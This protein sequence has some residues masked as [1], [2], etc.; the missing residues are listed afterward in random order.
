[1]KSISIAILMTV[2]N[3]REKTIN[4]LKALQNC[5]VKDL[6]IKVYL[7]DDGC[8]DGTAEAVKEYFDFVTVIDGNGTLFWNRGMHLAWQEAEKDTPLYFLW[9]NDDTIL[10]KDAIKRLIDTSKCQNDL[11][12]IVGS[13]TNSFN[14]KEITYGGRQLKRRYPIIIP[15]EDK[16]TECDTFNGN[17]VLI[18]RSVFLKLGYNDKYYHH[19]FGDYDYGLR[20]HYCGIKNYIAPGIYGY[21]NRNNPIPIFQRKKYNIIKRYKLL[22]SPLG[23]NPI[24]D[25][26]FNRKYHSFLY[27]ILHFIKLHINVLF[28]KDHTTY[29]Q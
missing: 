7:V 11:S 21:C 22:Y 6:N 5:T 23:Y 29:K 1:M 14:D 28:T 20:A 10:I 15:S 19:S 3:R 8:T 13:T 9:L 16:I 17:I 12:I 27:S 4:C 26:H 18:P 25:F 24:E 2:H